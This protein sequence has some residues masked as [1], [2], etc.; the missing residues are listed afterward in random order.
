MGRSSPLVPTFPTA[1]AWGW[2]GHGADILALQEG[3]EPV[4]DGGFGLI[5][6]GHLH[7]KIADH[8]PKVQRGAGF[9][10]GKLFGSTRITSGVVC[11]AT[12][13]AMN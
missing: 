8:R 10:E 3:L 12:F 11:P 5:A 9:W 7:L 2:L 13:F 1:R 4:Q 6:Q